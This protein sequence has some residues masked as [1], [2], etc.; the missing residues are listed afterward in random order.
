MKL[1]GFLEKLLDGVAIAWLPLGQFTNYEQP[2]KYLV[3]A[4][5]Y[6]DEFETPVL[7]AGKTFILGYTDET[8][9]IYKASQSPVIIFDDFTTASK[10]V[11]FDFKAKSSAMKMITSSD[12]GK[13]LLKYIY[14]WLNTLPSELVDGD[15]KRHWIG[16]YTSKKIPIPCP[17]NL[18][19][20]LEIQSEI[21]RILDTFAELG[22]ELNA[23]LK[24]RKKQYSYYRDQLL[25]FEGG[26]VEWKALADVGEFIRGK[27]FTK[28]DY[29][30]EGISVIHYGEIYTR[31]GVWADHAF[32]KVRAE[33]AGSLRY[34]EPGDVV[35]TDVGETV[36]EVGKAVAWL[37]GEKVAIHD[38]CYAFRHSMNPKFVSYCMQTQSF[39][40]KKAKHVA[41]TKV[42]TLL[43]NGFSKIEIP[44]PFPEDHERSLVEQARIVEIL[45]KFDVLTNSITEGLP[46]E[47]ALRQKQFEH[48]R[49][50]LLSFAK[51]EEAVA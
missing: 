19:K 39:I 4:T 42:N 3:A 23:E 47:I 41:R 17:D 9:G 22:A 30:E 27:R 8:E 7:T 33:M 32:S 21:V 45:E 37:G 36:E 6:S 44:V 49:D 1:S 28:A 50:L 40:T 12:E 26:K 35:L 14:Y 11:D 24:V 48:Y 18:K 46:R 20:S 29:A 43:I 2:T 10:W 38:H 16:S 31:Y 5:S 51:P 13:V 25:S 15:H 34:A